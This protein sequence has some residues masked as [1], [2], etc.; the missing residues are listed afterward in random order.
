[1]TP[2]ALQHLYPTLPILAEALSRTGLMCKTA[3]KALEARLR[4]ARMFTPGTALRE[5]V[6]YVLRPADAA[7]F[8]AGP[9]V[10]AVTEPSAAGAGRLLCLNR[11]ADQ[12][13]DRLLEIFA[14]YQDMEDRLDGLVFSNA[15]LQ[16]VCELG[17]ELLGN[18]LCVH[19]DWFVMAARSSELTEVL[20]PDYIMTSSRE[21]LPRIIVDDFKNDAEYLETYQSRRAQLWE[22]E[23]RCLYVNLW[24]GSVYRGRLLVV[25]YH[26]PFTSEDAMVCEVLAQRAVLLLGPGLSGEGR[27]YRSMDDIVLDLLNH[28]RP[29]AQEEA[30]FLSLLDWGREDRLVLVRLAAQQEGAGVMQEH[31]LHS[32]LF[33]AF[34]AGYVL[35]SDHQQCVLLNLSRDPV[36]MPMLRHA[37]A[38]LCRDYCLYAGISSPVRGPGELY[39]A[40]RQ[41]RAA[42]DRAFQ[43]RSEKWMLTFSDCALQYMLSRTQ[44]DMEP[45]SLAAPELLELIDYDREND[46]RYF[47]TLRTYLIDYRRKRICNIFR[48]NTGILFCNNYSW[49]S[50]RSAQRCRYC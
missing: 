20:P 1:M 15:G 7:R 8:P 49:F 11:S 42:L 46:T 50:L 28:R 6:L 37:L 5:D 32:D 47:E 43:L 41:A 45:R 26:R 17:A 23:P 18:P 25:Q 9:Y 44:T 48:I 22:A 35:F 29:G 27:T 12:V 2:N 3:G 33:Q 36:S 40:D 13:L 24:D 14:R 10:C 16:A 19:D 31:V 34:P 21:F 4:G 30:R 38:P 39:I